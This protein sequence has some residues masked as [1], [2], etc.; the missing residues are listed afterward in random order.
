MWNNFFKFVLN[1]N[2]HASLSLIEIKLVCITKCMFELHHY[3][4]FW[5]F[6]FWYFLKG[7]Y[8]DIILF[9]ESLKTKIYIHFMHSHN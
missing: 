1:L 3:F 4:A 2:L 9:K 8:K 6:W 5:V 7:S